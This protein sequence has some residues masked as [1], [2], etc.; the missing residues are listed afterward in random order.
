M[1]SLSEPIGVLGSLV[2][3]GVMQAAG[4]S[5]FMQAL[6]LGGAPSAA[7]IDNVTGYS[8]VKDANPGQERRW[9]RPSRLT[10]SNTPVQTHYA[11]SCIYA[12]GC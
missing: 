9:T 11:A 1:S 2:V 10:R 6:G 3:L 12:K 8:A 4:A 5:G 7:M